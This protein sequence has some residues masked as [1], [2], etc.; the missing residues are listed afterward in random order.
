MLVVLIGDNKIHKIVLPQI[1]S[2]NYVLNSDNINKTIEIQ[3]LDGEWQII[4]NKKAKIVNSKYINI[5]NDKIELQK[6]KTPFKSKI[7]LK[8]YNTFVVKFEKIKKLYLLYCLPVYEDNWIHLDISNTREIC[9]GKSP[10]NQIVYNNKIV[11]DIHAKLILSNGRWMLENIDK[12]YG[13]FLNNKLIVNETKFLFNGDTIFIMG[14][15]IIMMGN[16]IFINNPSSLVKFNE[17]YLKIEKEEKYELIKEDDDDNIIELYSSNDYFYRTP[18]IITKSEKD[19]IEIEA[20]PSRLNDGQMPFYLTMGTTLTMGI[21]SL[22][23]FISTISSIIS[24]NSNILDNVLSLTSAV[25]MI[26]SMLLIPMLMDRWERKRDKEYEKKRQIRYKQYIENKTKEV[27]EL[28]NEKRKNLFNDYAT[29]EECVQIILNKEKRLWERTLEDPD[30]L[31]INLGTGNIPLDVEISYPKKNILSMEDEDNLNQMLNDFT[32]EITTLKNAP[33]TVSLVR[34]SIIGIVDENNENIEKFMQNLFI[35]LMTFQDYNDLKF[36]FLLKKDDQKKWEYV[37]TFPYVWNENKD[38]RFFEDDYDGM[39]E[40]SKYLE[41]EYSKRKDKRNLDNDDN[42]ELKGPHYLIISDDYRKIENL[43]IIKNLI[44]EKDNIGF[45]ML[46]MANNFN[47]LPNECKTFITLDKKVGKLFNK[48]SKKS[49]QKE[50]V[51]DNENM[52]FFD[53]ISKTIANI[54]VKTKISEKNSLPEYYTFLD[55]YNVGLIEQLNVLDRW[56]GKDTTLS[57]ATPIGIKPSG[58][59]INLDLHEKYHGPHGLIAGS[60][61]SGKSE[62]IITYI[63]SLAINY[64]PNDVAFI[65]IDY[66]GGGLAGAFKKQDVELPHLVGTITNIDK[67]GLHRSL[68]SIQ[69]ELKRRQVWFNEARDMT[70]EGTIDIYKYQKLY[71]TGVIKRPIPHLFIIC[72][73]FAELKQQQPEFMEEL[74]SVS[75]IGRSLGVHLILATQKPSGIVDDQMRSNSKFAICLKVQDEGDSSE[76]I[77]RPDAAYLKQAGRFYLKV[78]KDDYF[79]LGQSGWAG[80][81][82]FPSDSKRGQ[83]ENSVKFISNTGKVIKEVNNYTKKVSNSNGEQ[84]T[85]IVKHLYDIAQKENIHTDNLWLDDIPEKIYLNEVK[86]KYNFKNE[87]KDIIVTV[88]E[89]DDPSNQAQGIANLDISKNGNIVI[90]GSADS[91]K[92]TLMSTMVYDLMTTYSPEKIWM[93]ILDF[94]TESFRIFEKA[95][96]VG[97]V[98]FENDKEKIERFFNKLK[99]ISKERKEVL[100]EYNGDYKFYL[101]TS[102]KSM[103]MIIVFINGYDVFGEHYLDDYD[104]ILLT[105]TRDGL[106]TGI[107]FVFSTTSYTDIRYRLADNFRQ[108]IALS[109]NNIGDYSSIF[110]DV[111]NRVPVHR[112]G[113]GF[114]T[115]K[116]GTYEFQTAKVFEP[117]DYNSLMKEKIQELEKTYNTKAENIPILPDKV[118]LSDLKVKLTGLNHFPI[119]L[120]R[121]DLKTE[122]FDFKDN[123]INIITANEFEEAVQFTNNIWVVLKKL[124]NLETIILDPERKILPGRNELKENYDRIIQ[125]INNKADEDNLES[126]NEEILCIVIGLNK[127][128]EY[129]DELIRNSENDDDEYDEEAEDDYDSE[130]EECSDGIEKFTQIIKKSEKKGNIT[131]IIVDNATKIKEH[132]YDEWYEK[133]VIWVGN[134]IEEQYL[135]DVNA[136]RKEMSNNCGC[137]FGYIDKKNK[138]IMLKLLEMKEKRED[139][140]DE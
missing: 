137:S 69:S 56:N 111:K 76:V 61:G 127:F 92:E 87:K 128:I 58:K 13:T 99:E 49:D 14:L 24:G 105:L 106:K 60:T 51:F 15:K 7:I 78:G 138:T 98:I 16:S 68:V 57:L 18:R 101:E 36:V 118:K 40:I 77:E 3:A 81:P 55:M 6:V 121:K 46:F 47:Q 89:Y 84:L 95:P 120:K 82:Y 108:K 20:P 19:L 135:L 74:V 125:K 4:S 65:L 117:K 129:L 83:E 70:S 5:T 94:G 73:E 43:K 107:T 32:N 93:Y 39:D 62:F 110:E 132:N 50:F 86:E 45:S 96:H 67:E 17:K 44:K 21:L 26:L 27:N 31:T 41:N 104:D 103:P 130:E 38:F 136:T 53:R 34:E 52:F 109:L 85:N 79:E 66:K 97:E 75:R 9:I 140:D 11:S 102:G 122:T 30:F 91:G 54:P 113:R 63:L 139:D 1:P 123:F 134:G 33:V 71:H 126:K 80:A 23:T 42:N 64:H 90:Y 35:Q 28:K 119:G 8:E 37:K 133:N 114:I 25:V 131:F 2:G 100:A 72:D 12:K 29:T 115:L 59:L 116:D 10:T 48:E 124:K 22:I 112:F 88:G